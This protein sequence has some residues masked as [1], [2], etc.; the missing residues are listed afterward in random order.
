MSLGQAFASFWKNYVNFSGRARRAEYW[1]AVLAL[2]LLVIPLAILDVF[3]FPAVVLENSLG[4]ASGL[5]T[6]AIILPSISMTVRRLHD[7]SKSGWWYLLTFIPFVGGI[8]LFVF[9]VLDSTPGANKW[10]ESPKGFVTRSVDSPQGG[11][12]FKAAV[13]EVTEEIDPEF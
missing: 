3:L 8:V 2:V 4:P 6:I 1:K 11:S 9:M 7:T 13:Y 12:G 10:G 5:F